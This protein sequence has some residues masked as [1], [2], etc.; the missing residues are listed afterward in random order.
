MVDLPSFRLMNA[1]I[2]AISE[3]LVFVLNETY[4]SWNVFTSKDQ[5]DLWLG[6][7]VSNHKNAGPDKYRPSENAETLETSAVIP[8]NVIAAVKSDMNFSPSSL[9]Y[10]LNLDKVIGIMGV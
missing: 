3:P 7:R 9:A 6:G 10:P 1:F 4:L 5:D 2:S 8:C